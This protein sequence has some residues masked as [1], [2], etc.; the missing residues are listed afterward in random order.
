MKI[1]MIRNMIAFV[2]ALSLSAIFFSLPAGASQTCKETIVATTTDANFTLNSDG[3]ATDNT[4]GLMWMRCSL[5]QV[6]DG[7]ICN[8]KPASFVWADA[9]KAAAGH[10]FAGYSEWRLPNKNELESI[11]EGRCFSP[12]INISVFPATPAVYYWSSSPYA[13][14]AYAAWS[15]DFGYGT[16]NASIKTGAIHVRLVRDVE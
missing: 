7:K 9:L 16:V 6:W 14:M 11:V 10:E 5:G 3:T 13:G 4:T 15:I 2:L 12:A 1:D 8:G